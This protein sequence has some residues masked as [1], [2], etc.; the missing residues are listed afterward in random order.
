MHGDQ[1]PTPMPIVEVEWMDS[2]RQNGWDTPSTYDQNID[3]SDAGLCRTAGYLYR[4][5]KQ[6]VCV[7]LSQNSEGAICDL[8]DIP[9]CAVR[10]IR[11]IRCVR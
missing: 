3:E 10:S 6:H 8:I 1:W 4:E 2:M 7:V 5:D 11:K 9:R